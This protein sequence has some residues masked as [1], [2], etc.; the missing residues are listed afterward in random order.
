MLAEGAESAGWLII[1]DCSMRSRVLS[2]LRLAL[3]SVVMGVALL[4]LVLRVVG[5]SYSPL[6]LIP[7]DNRNDF[8]PVHMATHDPRV[9]G[10]PLTVFDPELLWV[11]NP[12]IGEVISA[13]GTRGGPLAEARAQAQKLVVAVGDS[14]TLGPL[15]GPDHWPGYLQDLI[16][17]NAPAGRWRV[18]NAGVYGYSSFQGLRR[19]R[20]VLKHRPD[21]VYFS[22][23]ANDAHPVH[24]TDAAYAQRVARLAGWQ[25]LRVAPPLL[26]AWWRLRDDPSAAPLTHRVPLPDYVRNLE[27]FVRLAREAGA[28]PILLTRPYRGQ[29]KDPDHWMSYAPLYNQATRDVAARAAVD[30]V[31][32]YE[33]FR[34][35]PE[36]FTDES[37][38]TRRGYQRMAQLL[39]ADLHAKGLVETGYVYRTSVY[40]GSSAAPLP[41]LGEG[42]YAAEDWPNGPRGRWTGREATAFLE[43]RANEAGLAI[44]LDVFRGTNRTR[45]RIEAGGR[46][47]LQIDHANG[48]IVRTL[49]VGGVA[50][51][52]IEVHLAVDETARGAG[53]DTRALGLFVHSLALRPTALDP[54]VQP[55]ELEDDRG[56]LASGFWLPETWA[57]GRRGRWTKKEAVLRL[58]RVDGEDRLVL[59]FSLESPRGGTSGWLEVNGRRLKSFDG[60]AA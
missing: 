8:R 53:K 55:A 12:R 31:D 9:S 41:E 46:T 30:V 10:E 32:V 52:R 19:A 57:D 56:E 47:L 15:D 51:R 17:L 3:F 50:D 40:P 25:W 54:R 5:Y 45:G 38:F 1:G 24:R 42:W 6:A 43:R 28:R 16:A 22:F 14:N 7:V 59:D 36:L 21:V 44:D 33:A 35:S 37:H 60:R 49:D 23:G 34:S 48:R 29:S 11:P 20:Q 58:G 18:V 2:H 27:E 13:D 39:L 26:N 4:E